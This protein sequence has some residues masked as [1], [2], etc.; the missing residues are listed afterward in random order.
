[1]N[2]KTPQEIAAFIK[3]RKNPLLVTG[4]L[5]DVFQMDGRKLIDYAADIARKLDIVVAATANTVGGL[6]ARDVERTKKMWIGEMLNYM[7]DPWRKQYMQRDVPTLHS[8]MGDRPD[9]LVLMG[10]SSRVTDW[11][12]SG[13]KDIDTVALAPR[14][15]GRATCTLP[16]TTS[17]RQWQKLLDELVAAL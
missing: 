4:Y 13:L 5:C 7:R 8:L 10:Y 1:M 9:L 3:T 12:I 14:A 16:D 17:M 6:R 15:V 2:V 11:L